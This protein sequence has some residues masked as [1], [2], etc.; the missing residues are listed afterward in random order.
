MSPLLWPSIAPPI[1][2]TGQWKGKIKNGKR[3]GLFEHYHNNGQLNTKGTYRDGKWDGVWE[4]FNED[5]SL[6][7]KVIY[8][9]GV[10]VK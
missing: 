2:V 7:N 6:Q 8:K 5:G 3:N 9:D 10:K 1:T 4:T